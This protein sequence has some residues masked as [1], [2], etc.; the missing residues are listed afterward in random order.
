MARFPGNNSIGLYS[1]ASV[2]LNGVQVATIG[3]YANFDVIGVALD[4]IALT[5]AFRNVTQAGAWS[6]AFDISSLGP[7]PYLLGVT[8]YD[9]GESGTGNFLGPFIGTPPSGFVAWS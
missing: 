2:W 8:I 3:G 9:V 7:A 4:C 6:T 5:V 1:G